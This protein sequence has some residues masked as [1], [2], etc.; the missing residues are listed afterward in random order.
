MGHFQESEPFSLTEPEESEENR[1]LHLLGIIFKG[2]PF[3][4]VNKQNISPSIYF[5][6]TGLTNRPG[7]E[8]GRGKLAARLL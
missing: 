6:D 1:F 3:P 8:R 7:V 2:N 4:S 5:A